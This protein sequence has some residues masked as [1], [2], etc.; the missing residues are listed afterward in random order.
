[1]TEEFD[2]SAYFEVMEWAKKCED[3]HLVELRLWGETAVGH[4]SHYDAQTIWQQAYHVWQTP[5][6]DFVLEDRK[7]EE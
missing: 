5:F 6:D 2:D 4:L 7:D 3:I 1:M